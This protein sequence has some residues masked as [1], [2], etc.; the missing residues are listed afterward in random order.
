MLNASTLMSSLD[1]EDAH[2]SEGG[3]MELGQRPKTLGGIRQ[4]LPCQPTLPCRV[5]GRAKWSKPIHALLDKVLEG[6]ENAK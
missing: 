6:T 5:T 4:A 3:I 1:P 2:W